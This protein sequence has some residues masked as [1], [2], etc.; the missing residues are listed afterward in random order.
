MDEPNSTPVVTPATSAG[1]SLDHLTDK[2]AGLAPK[3]SDSQ[4]DA[5]LR[6]PLKMYNERLAVI[7]GEF[8]AYRT[9]AQSGSLTSDD[10]K[11]AGL[12]I[13]HLR[14]IVET[15]GPLPPLPNFLTT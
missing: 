15:A 9:K 7:L 6:A 11:R 1:V 14:E 4:I 3:L 12:A 2:G 8:E 13:G 10:E 5:A